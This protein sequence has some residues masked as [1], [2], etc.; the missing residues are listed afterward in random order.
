MCEGL[1]LFLKTFFRPLKTRI[2]IISFKSLSLRISTALGTN[3]LNLFHECGLLIIHLK[4][5]DNNNSP[6]MTIVEH[7]GTL[8]SYSVTT[9]FY[10]I[11][12]IVIFMLSKSINLVRAL[13]YHY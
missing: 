7:S 11:Y 8:F 13:Y 10:S 3:K 5:S 6:L 12:I 2:I 9:D 1:G 4:F